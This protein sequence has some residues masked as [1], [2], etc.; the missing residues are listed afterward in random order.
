MNS[1]NVDIPILKKR[2]DK[3]KEQIQSI[4]PSPKCFE[5]SILNTLAHLNVLEKSGDLTPRE[6]KTTKK[7]MFD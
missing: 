4:G 5:G 6:V 7:I 1:L 2:A 3:F